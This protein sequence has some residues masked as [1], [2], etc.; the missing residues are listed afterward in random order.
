MV[1][2]LLKQQPSPG[3][4]PRLISNP[5]ELCRL[6][7]VVF[8]SRLWRFLIGYSPL[9]GQPGS[10]KTEKPP[11][12][13]PINNRFQYTNYGGLFKTGKSPIWRT[14]GKRR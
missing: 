12:K 5:G 9:Y 6:V 4:Q 11:A 2:F 1:S 7:R 3:G 10:V 14:K 13:M 8:T